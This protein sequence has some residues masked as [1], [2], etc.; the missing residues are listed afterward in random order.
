MPTI[1]TDTAFM[2]LGTAYECTISNKRASFRVKIGSPIGTFPEYKL[3]LGFG[4]IDFSHCTF[5]ISHGTFIVS[6]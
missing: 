2:Y 5:V 3:N 1:R 6:H 4:N